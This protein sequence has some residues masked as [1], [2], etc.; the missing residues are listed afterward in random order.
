MNLLG[1]IQQNSY[2]T[3]IGGVFDHASH[4]PHVTTT[5]GSS[6]SLLSDGNTGIHIL[7]TCIGHLYM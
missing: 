1:N 7:C 2:M 5:L 6:V 3:L 4:T